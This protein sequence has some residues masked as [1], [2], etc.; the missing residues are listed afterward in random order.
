MRDFKFRQ[1][2]TKILSDKFS[3]TIDDALN[4]KINGKFFVE[5]HGIS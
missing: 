3:S 4:F 1:I 5:R 2:P